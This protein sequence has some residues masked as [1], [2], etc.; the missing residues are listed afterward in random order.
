MQ[1]PLISPEFTN[2]N[3]PSRGV[4][5]RVPRPMPEAA[6]IFRTTEDHGHTHDW[7]R[8]Q[9]QTSMNNDHTHRVV[10]QNGQA[11]V[12]E[13]DGH[14]HRMMLTLGNPLAEAKTIQQQ[15]IQHA[16]TLMG[17]SPSTNIYLALE[18]TQQVNSKWKAELDRI[19]KSSHA[20]ALFKRKV[21]QSA[22]EYRE[23]LDEGVKGES[24]GVFI[25]LPEPLAAEFPKNKQD[26]S[27]PHITMLYVG[28]CDPVKYA[29]VLD[30][31][32]SV[33]KDWTPFTLDVSDYGEFVATKPGTAPEDNMTIAHMI[34]RV[35]HGK[36]L[37]DLHERLWAEC[38]KRGVTA[39]HFRDGPF[40]P[41]TTLAYVKPGAA[42]YSGPR[43]QGRFVVRY[44]DLW[45]ASPDSDYGYQRIPL[46][47]AA[48][49]GAAKPK[50]VMV[51]ENATAMRT[52][53]G[54]RKRP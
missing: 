26:D 44:L 22:A 9:A 37:A 43:P 40:K 27:P 14:D 5:H 46:G 39:D 17:R 36:T 33:A 15:I 1:V 3:M 50:A 10:I 23:G 34:P 25:R 28:E 38:E 42:A 47:D 30:A 29:E 19:E 32:R 35:M 6:P 7:S 20:W 13:A 51:S 45:G 16:G 4:P 8:D 41:H 12:L 52:V 18:L 53:S 31:V 49:G 21:L 48:G 2:P 24:V 54:H 11:I